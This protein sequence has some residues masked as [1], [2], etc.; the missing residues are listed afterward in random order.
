MS[1]TTT[2]TTTTGRDPL[3]VLGLALLNLVG[4]ILVAVA[5]TVWWAV[6]FPMVSLPIALAVVAGV[7]VHPLAG[8]GV[9]GGAVAGIVLWR[10]RSPQT[11]ERWITARARARFLALFRYR[12]RWVRLLTACQ[13]VVLDGDRVR[14][15]RLLEVSIGEADDLVRVRMVP[16][17]RPDDYSD[18]ADQLAHAFGAEECRV[19]VLGPGLVELNFRYHD[20]LA[21]PVN[22]PQV[23][24]GADWMKGAA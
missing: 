19:R 14:V 2:T 1:T 3:D 23:I 5:V 7:L 24:D 17:H 8:A 16:G 12:R 21:E 15:P 10:V 13:L 9:A 20:A 11:F 18:R 6:L 22:L 4:G